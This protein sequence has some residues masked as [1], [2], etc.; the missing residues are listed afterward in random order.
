MEVSTSSENVWK[1]A[2]VQKMCGGKLKQMNN[3][4]LYHTESI[5]QSMETNSTSL[6]AFL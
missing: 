4:N 3:N 1:K 2:Q 6:A 5:T